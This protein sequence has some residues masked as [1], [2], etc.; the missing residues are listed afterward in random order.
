MKLR[1][2]ILEGTPVTDLTPLQRLESLEE[3]DLDNTTIND[4]SPIAEL[5][6][7]HTINMYRAEVP[8]LAPLVRSKVERR[9]GLGPSDGGIRNWLMHRRAPHLHVIRRK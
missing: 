6:N 7:L 5:K 8:N 4:L 2:L 1:S 3:L 9:L